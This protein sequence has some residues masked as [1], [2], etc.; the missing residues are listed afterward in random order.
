[1][2]GRHLHERIKTRRAALVSDGVA[3]LPA[4]QRS[5]LLHALPAL[6]SLALS[7]LL[8]RGGSRQYDRAAGH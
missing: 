7:D 8:D 5:A 3:E 4:D 6:E 2:K 1:M